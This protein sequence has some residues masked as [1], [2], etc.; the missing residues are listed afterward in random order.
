MGKGTH[1]IGQPKGAAPEMAGQAPDYRLD[2]HNAV[3]QRNGDGDGRIPPPALT[4]FD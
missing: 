3:D 4:L 2:H 1:F